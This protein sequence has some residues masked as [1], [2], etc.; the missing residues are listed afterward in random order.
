MRT[1]Y[2]NYLFFVTIDDRMWCIYD[3]IKKKYEGNQLV[4]IFV[5]FCDFSTTALAP[6]LHP[7]YCF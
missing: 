2:E 1:I 6:M 5:V 4:N 3:D 7:C